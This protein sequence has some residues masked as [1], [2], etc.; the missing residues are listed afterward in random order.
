M[1]NPFRI[2]QQIYLRALEPTDAPAIVPWI[3]DPEVTR[4]IGRWSA[5]SHTDELEFIDGMRKSPSDHVLGIALRDGDALVGLCGLHQINWQVREAMFGIMVG[6][7]AAQG[8]GHGSE[9]TRLMVA[10]AF[11]TLNLN[12]VWLDVLADH[13]RAVGVYER[14]GFVREGLARQKHYREG[15]YR[16]LLQMAILRQEWQG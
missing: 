6:D 8:R 12:R 7:R 10:F 11:E 5:V 16:D 14:A 1:K 2:G 3:N 9:A 15:R 13:P 4:T